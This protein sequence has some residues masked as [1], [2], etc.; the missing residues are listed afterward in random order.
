[1]SDQIVG[2]FDRE[3]AV[4]DEYVVQLNRQMVML[5]NQPSQSSHVPSTSASVSNN[6]AGKTE[7]VMKT[8]GQKSIAPKKSEIVTA[9][10]TASAPSTTAPLQRKSEMKK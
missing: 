5:A 3:A 9:P 8:D 1:M 4:T 10:S 2:V 6:D 7:S